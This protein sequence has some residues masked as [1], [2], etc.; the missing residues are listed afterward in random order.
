MIFELLKISPAHR[1]FY[2]KVIIEANVPQDLDL[3]KFQSMVDHLTSPY[4][5]SFSKEDDNSPSH[6]YKK[7]LYIEFMI[8]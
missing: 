5:M 3:D 6:L 1:W 7:K 8:Q 4:Y 2:D